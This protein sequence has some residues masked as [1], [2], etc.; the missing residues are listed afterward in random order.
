MCTLR[1]LLEHCRQSLTSALY[2]TSHPPLIP[3]TTAE[4][5]CRMSWT[6]TCIMFCLAAEGTDL[7]GPRV[8]KLTVTSLMGKEPPAG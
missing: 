5:F 6:E 7:S 3:S 4:N 2:S 8:H 1:F